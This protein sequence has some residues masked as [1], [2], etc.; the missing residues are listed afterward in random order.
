MPKGSKSININITADTRKLNKALKDSSRNMQR[1]GRRASLMGTDLMRSVTVPVAL[2]GGALLKFGSDLDANRKALASVMGSAKL[3]K[4]EFLAL[5]EAAKAPGLD[6]N[7]AIQGSL[8]FQSMGIEADRA[9][10]MLQGFGKAVALSGGGADE[11]SRTIQQLSDMFARGAVRMEDWRRIQQAAPAVIKA[12]REEFQGMGNDMIKISD[13]IGFDVFMERLTRRL[14]E[15]EG[16]GDSLKNSLNN[17]WSSSKHL[18]G[19]I[20]VLVSEHSGLTEAI[21]WAVAW[22]DKL[23]LRIMQDEEFAAKLGKQISRLGKLL[24]WIAGAGVGLKAIGV[25]GML[26]SAFLGA[27][28]S[29]LK[30]G[31]AIGLLNLGKMANQLKGFAVGGLMSMDLLFGKNFPAKLGTFLKGAFAAALTGWTWTEFLGRGGTV[32]TIGNSTTESLLNW[33]KRIQDAQQKSGFRA[34][35]MGGDN[36]I[37]QIDEEIA[38][39]TEEVKKLQLTLNALPPDI[40]ELDESQKT[41]LKNGAELNEDLITILEKHKEA[42][43]MVAAEYA[44]T[45]NEQ[46]HLENK[47]KTLENTLIQLHAAGL[48]NTQAFRD[49][50]AE[51]RLLKR[52]LN[53][54]TSL[55]SLTKALED[56]T[57]SDAE[58]AFLKLTPEEKDTLDKL[59]EVLEPTTITADTEVKTPLS[60]RKPMDPPPDPDEADPIT[61]AT[62]ANERMEE[63]E[64]RL[65]TI[66][67]IA[68][69]VGGAV[70]NAFASMIDG[71]QKFG[72]AMKQM[73]RDV[74]K[75]LIRMIVKLLIVKAIMSLLN[76]VA[77]GAGFAAGAVIPNLTGIFPTMANGGIVGKATPAI[78]GEYTNAY[79]K[80]EMVG[81]V[82]QWAGLIQQFMGGKYG[83]GGGGELTGVLRGE[84]ILIAVERSVN[85]RN[86]RGGGLGGLSLS[87]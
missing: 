9:R 52:E 22:M 86:R 55:E 40:D 75:A 87:N 2:A 1:W 59:K 3:A 24:I 25:V 37:E 41:W 8:R 42:M 18:A 30:V 36:T 51:Y 27:A 58:L 65:R 44:V 32:D 81:R 79:N 33:K 35:F 62:L 7:A 43:A 71:G 78:F 61:Q 14:N 45:G 13:E 46:S 67:S 53:D 57:A 21:E 23:A 49:L 28:N 11:F 68:G 85:N 4:Q 34:H 5:K 80:P 66:E 39:R 69:R 38:R 17:L 56:L 20:G 72:D 19:E 50:S 70:G 73:L 10:Q 48:G 77:P 64:D 6:F 82:D 15:T 54:I 47:V 60:L 63:A 26:G 12:A 83:M 29:V 76:A 74:I 16:A 84:D 31:N